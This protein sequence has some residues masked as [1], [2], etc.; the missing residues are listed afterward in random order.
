[1]NGS[2]KVIGVLGGGSWGTAL[3]QLAANNGYRVI[4]WCYE[5]DVAESINKNKENYR[6]HPGIKL[7]DNIHATLEVAEAVEG[8]EIIVSAVPSF[9][10]REIWDRA[11]GYVSEK[12]V[13]VSAT[14]GIE[15][16]TLMRMSEV[17]LQVTG[18]NTRVAVLSGPSFAKEVIRG[19][20]AAVTVA[21]SHEDASRLACE[22]F[23]SSRFR[24]Y[25]HHDVAGV[26][27]GGAIKN[28]MAIA[29]GLSDGLGF[30]LNT[31]AALITRGLHEI[32]RLGVKIG[33]DPVTF[34][35]LSGM[36]DLVLTATGDLSRNR[37]VGL[38]LARG[39]KLEQVLKEL[40]EVAEGVKTAPVAL[41]LASKYNV[42]M[43]ITREVNAIL[44]EGKDPV[45]SVKDLMT[46]EMKTEVYW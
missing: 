27:I 22:V 5:P 38:G 19:L 31:R 6:Y 42:E 34:S 13:V 36:G 18:E 2:K 16:D 35:G 39:K 24:T 33:A 40:G 9:A 7:S 28:V 21:S 26:E 44:F 11:K 4:M 20:P 10:V 45:S 14:K 37:R 46:R 25:I 3:A 29:V 41:A 1:M 15:E 43:P 8:M 17:I 32:M 23:H 30:G 12:A